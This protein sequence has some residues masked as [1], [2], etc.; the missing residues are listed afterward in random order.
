[1]GQARTSMVPTNDK[2]GGSRA[3]NKAA[4]A[5]LGARNYF[6]RSHPNRQSK[7]PWKSY[8]YD[9]IHG[10]EPWDATT[11]SYSV[12]NCLPDPFNEEM[13]TYNDVS[14]SYTVA[15]ILEDWPSYYFGE[16]IKNLKMYMQFGNRIDKTWDTVSLDDKLAAE[17]VLEVGQ[18]EAETKQTRLGQH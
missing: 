15:D 12:K 17:G 9:M 13:P 14:L 1:M 8:L 11:D 6:C 5:A 4:A 10:S 3:G 2:T 7:A 18:S 16:R